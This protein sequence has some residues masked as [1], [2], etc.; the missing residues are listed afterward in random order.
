MVTGPLRAA[1]RRPGDVSQ[2]WIAFMPAI[3]SLA[4]L[5]VELSF[6]TAYA[7]PFSETIAA[8]EP[9]PLA[10]GHV[11]GFQGLGISAIMMGVILLAVRRWRLSIGGQ[12][13]II[14]VAYGLTISIH[15]D[16]YLIPFE[17][18]T[19]VS[20][21]ASYWCLNPS[22]ERPSSLRLFAFGAQVIFY[23]LYFLT[24]ARTGGLW[25]SLNLW[26]GAIFL[27][28]ITGWLLS[29][30]FLPPHISDKKRT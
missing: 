27:A 15:E 10:D 13:M 4:L 19:G 12:T 30:A 14:T 17:I 6:F 5:L 3:L 2:S 8:M 7:H 24:L 18:F 11:F 25:W 22:I 1:W 21:E 26:S 29:Y 16:F 20:L 28:G 9:C 23:G